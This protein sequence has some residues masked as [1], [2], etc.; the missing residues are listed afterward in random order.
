MQFTAV[1][2]LALAGLASA[3]PAPAVDK[4]D[5]Y[6]PKVTYPHAGTVWR[7][8]ERHNVT[9]NTNEAPVHISSGS[10]IYLRKGSSTLTK[11]PLAEGFDLRKGHQAITVPKDIT[12]G[13]DYRIVLFGDSGN[14][15]SKFTI[16]KN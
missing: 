8:G 6:D 9:W 14:F 11:K 16:K 3:S 10:A 1:A 15:G 5:V 7:L 13:T 12:P 4:R 2:L